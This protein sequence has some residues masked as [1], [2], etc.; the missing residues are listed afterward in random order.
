MTESPAGLYIHEHSDWPHFR[1]SAEA[2]AQ[3][4]AA[5][6]H[7]QGLFQ[8]RMQTL[9]FGQRAHAVL[10]TLTDEVRTSSAIEGED[11]DRQQVR[12]SIARRLGIDIDASPPVDRHVEGAVEMALDAVRRAEAPLT[13]DRLFA[14]HGAL[15]PTGRSGLQRIRVGAW[16]DDSH[17]P[18]RVVS[19][20]IGRE[21]VHYEAPAAAHVDPEMSGFLA[22]FEGPNA[23]DPALKAALAHL[24]FVMIHPFEDGNGRVARA[25]MDL[26]LAR[27]EGDAPPFYSLSSQ[28]LQER[29]AYYA[30]LD[31]TGRGDL[32]VTPWLLWFL[33]CL[34]RALQSAEGV[35][36]AVLARTRF[37]DSIAD[38]PINERQR[39]MLTRLLDGWEGKLTT[40]KWAKI[41]KCSHDTALRDIQDLIA[42]GV[43]VM[44][45]AGGRSTSYSL[46]IG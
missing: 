29:S 14:W 22:W 44:D 9:G 37:W 30:I 43:L 7:R 4:L 6:R 13:A 21:R 19:G 11:L 10:E 20:P 42:N 25:I 41:A 18:M 39:L 31:K 34:A 12:S 28:I 1:W 8:G 40:A 45:E 16:R 36:N 3:P 46:R 32:D 5:V 33:G 23:V 38:I 26:A 17:G 15:F 35:V 27:S 2:L 24:W